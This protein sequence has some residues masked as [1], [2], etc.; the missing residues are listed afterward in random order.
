MQPKPVV[1]GNVIAPNAYIR[2][3]NMS[4]INNLNSYLKKLRA[5]ERYNKSKASKR[6]KTIKIKA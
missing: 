6:K 2:N 3:K 4:K 1:T 5:K